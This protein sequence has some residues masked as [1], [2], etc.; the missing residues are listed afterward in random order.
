MADD[1]NEIIELKVRDRLRRIDTKIT[2][3]M[4][5]DTMGGKL[6]EDGIDMIVDGLRVAGF[7]FRRL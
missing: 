3:H 2:T 5:G 4:I 6:S 1:D 7:G